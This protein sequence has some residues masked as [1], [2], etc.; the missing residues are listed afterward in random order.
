VVRAIPERLQ[1]S[2]PGAKPILAICAKGNTSA[3]V[4][5]GLR[6]LGYQAC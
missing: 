4:A 3:H 5:E 1:D 6:R 2:C